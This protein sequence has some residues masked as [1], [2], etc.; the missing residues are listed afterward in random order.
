MSR[1][2]QLLLVG[3]LVPSLAAAQGKAVAEIG[4]NLGVG[5]QSSGGATLTHFGVPGQGIL[6]QPTIYA[7]FFAGDAVLVEPQVAL[8]I[9]S[10]E[11]E[12]L[13]TVGLAGQAGYLFNGAE[14]NSPFVAG[15]VAFQA[16]S[17]GGA[18]ENDFALGGKVGYR[19]V[20]GTSVGVRVE[21]GYRRWFDT[22]LNEVTIGV[23]IGGIVRRAA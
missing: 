17:G 10:S 18:S 11:G 23:G 8:N 12:T 19:V 6:G 9:L 21:G 5:I 20:V 22:K 2:T 7:S 15:V 3:L 4:T 16:F 13:T 14:M 1:S